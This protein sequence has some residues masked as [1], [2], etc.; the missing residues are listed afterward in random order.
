MHT[1]MP[2]KIIKRGESPI[3]LEP[4]K[5]SSSTDPQHKQ[6]IIHVLVRAD[7]N[8]DCPFVGEQAIPSYSGLQVSL[9]VE[10]EKSKAYFHMSSGTDPEKSEGGWLARFKFGE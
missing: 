5:F 8:G 9:N 2:Y 4:T 10:K 7:R 1:I 3:R 6:N